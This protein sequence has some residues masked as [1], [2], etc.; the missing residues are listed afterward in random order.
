VCNAFAAL[1]LQPQLTQ[2]A[3]LSCMAAGRPGRPE[4][5]GPNRGL[6][7]KPVQRW[8][9]AL[10]TQAAAHAFPEARPP[11]HVVMRCMP[12]TPRLQL[13]CFSAATCASLHWLPSS[14]PD[15]APRWP[16]ARPSPCHAGHGDCYIGWCKCHEGW[17]GHDCAF[18]TAGTE[19]S[20]G[21]EEGERPWLKDVVRSPASR[22]PPAGA[23]KK[24]PLI[25][26]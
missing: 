21:M 25:Y 22:D 16:A 9:V 4:L 13:R 10:S 1:C 14:V 19:W 8:G 15:T 24:R 26:V 11:C 6:L 18:R 2:G 20:P 17:Y 12:C 7:P 5:R 23:R 3:A